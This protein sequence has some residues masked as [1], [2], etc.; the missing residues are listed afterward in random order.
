[1]GWCGAREQ[2]GEERASH[3]L[4][5]LSML[6]DQA[7]PAQRT[8]QRGTRGQRNSKFVRAPQE[9]RT[10]LSQHPSQACGR[11]C[12]GGLLRPMCEREPRG[13]ASR[14]RTQED[15]VRQIVLTEGA[16]EGKT[17]HERN[18]NRKAMNFILRN[19]NVRGDVGATTPTWRVYD[20]YGTQAARCYPDNA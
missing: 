11:P 4:A 13:C 18:T 9:A 10:S 14:W 6:L 19:M 12:R 2:Q 8:S 5:A 1:M 20:N 17:W 7:R 3:L 16:A 15:R